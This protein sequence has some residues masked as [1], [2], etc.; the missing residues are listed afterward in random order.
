MK[1]FNSIQEWIKSNPSNEETER[2]LTLINKKFD[3]ELRF[4]IMKKESNLKRIKKTEDF[5][6]E[7]GFKLDQ[8][9]KLR[10]KEL[11]NEIISL[12]KLLPVSKT[13]V[14][15]VEENEVKE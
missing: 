12:R 4:D 2:I 5:M 3:K 1:K 8:T 7:Q 15:K 6:L 13:R 10:K 9:F 14:K 11:E